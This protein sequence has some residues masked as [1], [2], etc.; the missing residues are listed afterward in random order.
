MAV[1]ANAGA[2]DLEQDIVPVGFMPLTDCAA[3]VMASVLGFDQRYG[4]KIELRREMSWSPVRDKLCDGALDASHALY[5]LV[6]GVHHFPGRQSRAAAQL[7]AR[8]PRHRSA[9]RRPPGHLAAVADGRQLAGLPPRRLLRR[10]AVE[11]AR[12]KKAAA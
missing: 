4:I 11:R 2:G 1:L 5:G 12:C 7:L 3:L 6:T 9:A 10:R 8:R